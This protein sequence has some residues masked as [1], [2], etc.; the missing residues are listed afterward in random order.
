MDPPGAGP[1][2]FPENETAWHLVLHRSGFQR[3]LY[4]YD[5][6]ELD[7][8]A[9]AVHVQRISDPHRGAVR[10][11]FSLWAYVTGIYIRIYRL[12]V[13]TD[14]RKGAGSPAA[15]DFCGTDGIFKALSV[16]AFSYRCHCG[17]YG[18]VPVQQDG[19]PVVCHRQ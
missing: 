12:A 15:H 13:E 5:T 19:D 7:C 17:N 2:L 18:R 6:E 1:Y 8:Q 16:C 14:H 10:P 4:E 3:H 11:F 9:K